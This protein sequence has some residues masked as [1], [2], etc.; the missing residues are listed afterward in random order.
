MP[1]ELQPGWCPETG[2][3]CREARAE[4]EH[5]RSENA[6]A[7]AQGAE[8]MRQAIIDRLPSGDICDPQRIADVVRAIVVAAEPPALSSRYATDDPVAA[9]GG[10]YA[11]L[12][13][14]EQIGH[15]K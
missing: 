4:V 15:D 12:V 2:R 7:W 6:R 1:T 10:E 8:W 13:D 14:N 5:L 3:F 11:N 9:S